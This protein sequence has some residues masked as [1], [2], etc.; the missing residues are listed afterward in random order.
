MRVA[1]FARY[2][3]KLQDELS[4]EAQIQ[5]MEAFVARQ[6]GWEITHRYALPETRSC[7]IE[8]S[9]E[10]QAMMADARARRFQVLLVHKLD[11]FGR[12]RDTSV[13]HKAMLRRLGVQVRSVCENL[14]DSI[15]DRAMEGM[16][17]V[18]AEWYGGN[19]G[20]ETRKGH[21]ALTRKGYWTGGK[22]P[23]GYRAESTWEGAQQRTRLVP[24]PTTGP[25]MSQVFQWYAE[26][27]AT[28]LIIARIEKLTGSP[29]TMATLYTRLRNP[30]YYG[31]LR[32]GVTSLPQGR[33]RRA[34]DE[35]TEGTIPGLVDE[36]LWRRANARLA[37]RGRRRPGATR[38]ETYAFS[39][40]CRCA[41]CGGPVVGN[42]Q[43]GGRPKYSCSN[44]RGG[45]CS[46]SA[47]SAPLLEEVVLNHLRHYLKRID[48]RRLLEAYSETLEPM[49]AQAAQREKAL[50]RQI[51][52]TR[53]KV[54]NLI[55][56]IEQ[57]I[58]FPDIQRRL[59]ELKALEA[60]LVGEVATCQIE[61]EQMLASNVGVVEEW[62]SKVL[63]TIDSSEP[64]DIQQLLA[65][66]VEVEID[67]KTKK[68]QLAIQ[69]PLQAPPLSF[70]LEGE[71][72]LRY[73]RSARTI[74][75]PSTRPSAR[76]WI[77]FS[78]A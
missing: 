20:Q 55:G 60:E 2:S 72:V 54:S 28:T 74:A 48:A 13:I 78:A 62:L 53:Q 39:G 65:H 14:G 66:V 61:V 71:D 33:P 34:G 25:V 76:L 59:T 7:E 75:R 17:E 8:K 4:L 70:R 11:R 63:A 31:Q 32:Y 38:I 40:L 21:R 47:V 15:M 16:L 49:R 12:N 37:E 29:W 26:G 57:G 9:P 77:P 68:G 64:E 18:M 52:E 67:L 58:I 44:R 73:G 10:F 1:L 56:A 51:A 19:L 5:E 36:E 22:V 6:K 23:F 69:L 46:H 27:E 30:L 45:G 35:V 43:G 50:W 3:S 24:C 42:R 41:L